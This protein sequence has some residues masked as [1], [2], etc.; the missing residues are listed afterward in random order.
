MMKQHNRVAASAAALLVTATALTFDAGTTPVLAQAQAGAQSPTG[1]HVASE[2]NEARYRVREQLARLDFPNDAVGRTSEISGAITVDAA[3]NIVAGASRFTINM[4]ALESDSDR[5]DNFIRRN[6]L[7]TADHPDAVFVPTSFS[8]LAFPLPES[9][10]LQFRMT[11]DLTIRGV[12]RPVT[13]DV[14]ARVSDDG[15][16]RGEATTQFTF[17]DFD[18]TKPRVASVLSVAD[19]IR[20][21]YTF[22]LLPAR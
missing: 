22:H 3:G 20:L 17:A 9:G 15:A 12:T 14:M 16:L 13:W 6:T 2:G 4:A 7:Q 8:G 10:V 19:D 18:I 1:W 11:G 21:E 5:R